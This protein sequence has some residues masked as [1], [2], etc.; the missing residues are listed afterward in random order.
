MPS[1]RL[2]LVCEDPSLARVLQHHLAQFVDPPPPDWPFDLARRQLGPDV[3]GTAV[4]AVAR[5]AEARPARRL[6][7]EAA[8]REWPAGVLLV[9][10]PEAAAAP[11]LGGLDPYLA[12][13][14][15]WPDEVSALGHR[16]RA[17]G[18]WHS[19]RPAGAEASVEET[20]ARC[21]RA[22]TPSLAPMAKQLA[23]AAA[24]D[25]TVLLTGETGTGKTYL[26]QL[27]HDCSP[28]RPHGFLVVP[29]GALAANLIESEFFGHARGAFT[30][31]DRAKEGKFQ[32]AG[33]GTLL[34]DEVDALGLDQQSNLLRVLETGEFEPVGSN[35]TRRCHA[36]IIAAS[37]LD[38]E[39]AVRQGRVR[40]DLFYRLHVMAFHLP[41]LRERV[42]DVA[43]LVRALVLRFAHK[44]QKELFAVSREALAALE[45]FPWPGNIRQLENALQQA[46]LV[47]QGPVLQPA[48]LPIPIQ[49]AT[50][51]RSG[52]GR[53]PAGSLS[54]H[55]DARERTVIE[56]AII[57]NDYSRVRAALALGISRVTLYKK[58]RKYGLLA[59]PRR[60]GDEPPLARPAHGR[61]PT[62]YS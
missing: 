10:A 31:A 9:T 35:E 32:A 4:V 25:V 20:I 7:Q 54:Q 61:A 51:R 18:P 22:Q 62:A 15:V 5:A 44:F 16:L 6:V 57:S 34:L 58:M 53:A 17:L 21:L 41:P 50:L 37:N 36:R 29:C 12:G 40:E 48:H 55:R 33:L 24:H 30:G 38:L 59:M 13:R 45:S 8:M 23:L 2:T 11:E 56:Q 43:P 27:I 14:F 42:R 28:R 52:Y 49:E 26:A 47:S 46:V 60:A 19:G 1:N 39:A 3:E